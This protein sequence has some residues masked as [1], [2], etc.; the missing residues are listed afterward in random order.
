MTASRIGISNKGMNKHYEGYP[1]IQ[2]A[3]RVWI[4]NFD[5]DKGLGPG[6]QAVQ[7]FALDTLDSMDHF[8]K[9]V[10]GIKYYGRYMD[11]AY[12]IHES[13]DYLKQLQ[14]NIGLFSKGYRVDA[15]P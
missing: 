7:V 2:Q 8:I 5:G 3:L 11:D 12:L 10:L 1:E 13:K 15:A 4:D 14:G 9:E 6:S